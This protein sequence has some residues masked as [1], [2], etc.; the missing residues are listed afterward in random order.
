VTV[1]HGSQTPLHPGDWPEA[2][3]YFLFRLGSLPD[4]GEL[5]FAPGG[6]AFP[7]WLETALRR[8]DFVGI[9]HLL[10]PEVK[11]NLACAAVILIHNRVFSIPA[12]ASVEAAF[13]VR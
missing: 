8:G 1:E 13:V 7:S 2:Q 5:R 4:Q 11:R 10:I 9:L 12:N 6:D 3:P